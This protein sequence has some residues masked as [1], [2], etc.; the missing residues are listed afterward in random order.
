MKPLGEIF[1]EVKRLISGGI[2]TGFRFANNVQPA[3]VIVLD[4]SPSMEADDYP[5]SRFVAAKQAANSFLQRC[6]ER[7]P[8]ALVGIVFYSE[9]AR[10][11]SGLMPV[12]QHRN[13]LRQAIESGEI[14]PATNISAGLSMACDELVAKGP[15]LNPDII[16]LTD[17]HATVGPDPVKT[18][19]GLKEIGIQIDIIGIGGSPDDVNESQLKQMASIVNG[20]LRYWFIRDRFALVRKFEA[21]ALGKA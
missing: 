10:V 18:A 5:P 17:G 3:F 15:D 12:K 19:A 8:E 9:S 11:A 7:T 21:L 16:L 1:D 20:Q 14:E 2:P 13:Q 6:A 4:A